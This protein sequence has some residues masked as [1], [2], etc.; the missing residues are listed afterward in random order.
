[1]IDKAGELIHTL[2][3]IQLGEDAKFDPS[4]MPQP[5]HTHK[6]L[7]HRN[8]RGHLKGGRWQRVLL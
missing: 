5:E 4:M 7:E 1:M 8:E 3:A 2:F 6:S